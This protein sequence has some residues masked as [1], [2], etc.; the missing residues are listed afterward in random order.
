MPKY[1]IE[2]RIDVTKIEKARLYEGKKGKYLTLT[3]FVNTGEKDQY[4]N[5]GFISHKVTKEESDA[6]ENGSIIGNSKVFWT[7]ESQQASAT[8][9]STQPAP[10]GDFE[11]D[12]IP[13]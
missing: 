11:D 13:F 6:G 9:S 2:L 8:Q 5:N 10:A 12:T 1:G 7:D 4:G 3:T